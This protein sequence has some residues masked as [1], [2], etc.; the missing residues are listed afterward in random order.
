M[1]DLPLVALRAFAAVYRH[2]G[3]RAAGRRLGIAHS[4]VSRHLSELEDWLGT[5]LLQRSSGRGPLAFTESGR[6]LAEATVDGLRRI[7]QA[8]SSVHEARSSNSVQIGAPPSVAVRWLLPRLPA[9]ERSHPELEVSV[10]VDRRKDDLEGELDVGI[11]MGRSP[12]PDLHCEPLMGDELYPVMSPG[13][14]RAHGRPRE[15]EQLIGL[16]LLHDRD[17]AATWAVWRQAFGPP[18][19]DVRT[20]PRFTSTDLVLRAA[21]QGQGVA[22]ARDRLTGDDLESGALLRPLGERS[23]RLERAYWLVRSS[24]SLPRP[25]ARTVIGWLKRQAATAGSGA[26]SHIES[27]TERATERAAESSKG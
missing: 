17:P 20:G 7:E 10:V 3:I 26:R 13:F 25:A 24:G 14:W 11:R 15:P 5:S 8:V 6:T 4:S 21:R 16:R 27:V 1:R 9:L 2:G 22:L 12:W 23:V 18:G 19:L